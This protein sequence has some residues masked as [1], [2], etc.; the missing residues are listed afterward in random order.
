VFDV[1]DHS[2]ISVMYMSFVCLDEIS[3]TNKKGVLWLLCRV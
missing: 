2:M 3:K 1:C